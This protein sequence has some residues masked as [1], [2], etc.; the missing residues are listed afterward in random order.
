MENSI[1][2]S[3]VHLPVPMPS[4]HPAEDSSLTMAATGTGLQTLAPVVKPAT[5]YEAWRMEEKPSGIFLAYGHSYVLRLSQK[6]ACRILL[7][8]RTL[9]VLD[10]ANVFDPYLVAELARK[11]GR[12]PEEFL[13]HIRVSRSFTCH[14]MLSLIR[15]VEKAARE[16]RSS[17]I[18]LLG[19]L[20]AFYDESV[21][22]Y[23]VWTIF[24]SFEKELDRLSQAGFRL[25]LACQQPSAATQRVFVQRL[26]NS[27]VGIASCWPAELAAGRPQ[28]WLLVRV[29]KPLGINRCWPVRQGEIFRTRTYLR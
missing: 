15:Q 24:R 29:E 7:E 6:L 17:L 16:W 8:A 2:P 22:N 3:S 19:P 9:M 18:L 27:A 13:R 1:S 5:L 23:E 20:T 4:G 14:Q 28:D 12:E 21:P 10:G 11:A 26:K 25:L